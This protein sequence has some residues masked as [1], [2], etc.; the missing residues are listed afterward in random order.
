VSIKVEY[1]KTLN[2]SLFANDVLIP[3]IKDGALKV[4][5]AFI[6]NL[7]LPKLEITNIFLVGSNAAFNYTQYSD[8]D[9]HIEVDFGKAIQTY[10]AAAPLYFQ[11][12]K[13][14]WNQNHS[15][16][17]GG[18]PVE[19]YIQDTND[20]LVASGIYSISKDEWIKKPTYQTP[21]FDG[22]DVEAKV[23]SIEQEVSMLLS[24]EQANQN[25]IKEVMDSIRDMRRSGLAKGGEFSSE[26]ICFKQLRNNGTIEKL[27]DAYGKAGDKELTVE[28]WLDS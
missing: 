26:N 12:V 11:S 5:D 13:S 9:L 3:K 6:A 18:Q 8:F 4:A 23:T 20:D 7:A 1:K 24:S 10:G 16:T 25:R 2:P 17:L 27:F 19:L 14:L 21:V 28:E 22:D 15:I